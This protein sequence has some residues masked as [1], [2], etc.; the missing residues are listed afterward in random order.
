MDAGPTPTLRCT[1]LA[2]ETKY[3]ALRGAVF[4]QDKDK[5]RPL[6]RFFDC[7]EDYSFVPL[8]TALPA[9]VL[10]GRNRS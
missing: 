1:Q 6:I 8:D 9:D 4:E 5:R 7:R 2:L 3:P 10:E